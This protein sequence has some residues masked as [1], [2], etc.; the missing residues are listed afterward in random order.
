MISLNFPKVPVPNRVAELVLDAIPESACES[1]MD[2]ENALRE[3]GRLRP[4][5]SDE[6][7]ADR[8]GALSQLAKANKTLAAHHPQFVVSPW[9][10]AA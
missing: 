5:T 6:D 9:G 10:R 4:L 8:E 7:R 1:A 2:A 3:I